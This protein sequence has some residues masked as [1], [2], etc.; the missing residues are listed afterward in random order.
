MTK[1]RVDTIESEWVYTGPDFARNHPMA[2]RLGAVWL[3]VLW[4]AFQLAGAAMGFVD[5]LGRLFSGQGAVFAL[6]AGL[7]FL[8]ILNNLLA[9]FGLLTRN[10]VAWYPVWVSLFSGIVLS[11]PLMIYWA[12][13]TR[14]NLLYRHRFGR[15]IWPEKQMP[16]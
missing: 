12:S 1:A 6:L 13:G 7:L 3:I 16:T 5:M 9:L 2:R 10:T 14:P 15:L 4:V 8:L 11:G